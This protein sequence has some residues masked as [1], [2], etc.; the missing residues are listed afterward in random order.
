MSETKEFKLNEEM[1]NCIHSMQVFSDERNPI[2]YNQLKKMDGR[3]QVII[4]L[5]CDE[6][7]KF[8]LKQEHYGR[9]SAR[10]ALL[11]VEMDIPE[12]IEEY[13]EEQ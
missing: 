7:P 5:R 2:T 11:Y 12:Y 1:L 3:T 6:N 13:E 9:L 4:V 10:E 8:K